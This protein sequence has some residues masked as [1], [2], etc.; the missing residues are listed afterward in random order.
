MGH[1]LIPLNLSSQASPPPE[2]SPALRK[3]A[4][5]GRRPLGSV[6]ELRSLRLEV[7]LALLGGGEQM[8]VLGSRADRCKHRVFLQCLVSAVLSIDGGLEEAKSCVFLAAGCQ[9]SRGE[10]AVFRIRVRHHV[11]LNLLASAVQF[12]RGRLRQR[13]ST[14]ANLVERGGANVRREF[15]ADFTGFGEF[16]FTQKNANGTPPIF[17]RMR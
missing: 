13:T 14:H 8:G 10:V 2:P 4:S 1:P 9:K 7:F 5:P 6:H 12:R 16:V 3:S 15:R 17:S 11:R